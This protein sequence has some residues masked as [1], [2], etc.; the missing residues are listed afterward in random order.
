MRK[1]SEKILPQFIRLAYAFSGDEV[2]RKYRKLI[3]EFWTN[4]GTR[5]SLC[6]KQKFRSVL[7]KYAEIS[8]KYSS[9]FRRTR[10]WAARVLS[11]RRAYSRVTLKYSM[12]VRR[13]GGD[14]VLCIT[15]SLKETTAC[16]LCLHTVGN[17]IKKSHRL[18]RS[19]VK[20]D[21]WRSSYSQ[22]IPSTGKRRVECTSEAWGKRCLLP[23][24]VG[25]TVPVQQWW[26]WRPK[27]ALSIPPL[28]SLSRILRIL[29]I[30]SFQ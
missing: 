11:I 13:K 30:P 3:E 7:K 6:R 2:K 20:S 27:T 8:V 29:R 22:C 1:I 25:C 5:H 26:V 21:H 19:R 24:L 12:Y 15:G 28:R 18:M 17:W 4:H 16:S 10:I 14:S 23:A 9:Q